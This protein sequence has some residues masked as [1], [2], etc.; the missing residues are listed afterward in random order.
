MVAIAL[1]ALIAVGSKSPFVMR[2]LTTL[3]FYFT[4][5]L[6]PQA[7]KG[8]QYLLKSLWTFLKWLLNGP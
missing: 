1:A 7:M 2:L 3:L 6:A 5:M 4:K 8:L